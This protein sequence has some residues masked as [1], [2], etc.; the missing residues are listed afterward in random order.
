MLEARF[1]PTL[2]SEHNPCTLRYERGGRSSQPEVHHF[3]ETYYNQG[4]LSLERQAGILAKP[5]HRCDGRDEIESLLYKGLISVMV[6]K[7]LVILP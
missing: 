4:P 6:W 7:K 3:I 2:F 1:P 5:A